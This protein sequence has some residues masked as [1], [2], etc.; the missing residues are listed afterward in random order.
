MGRG[1][2]GGEKGCIP[3]VISVGMISYASGACSPEKSLKF[4]ILNLLKMH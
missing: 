4:E 2:G 1:G 3:Y